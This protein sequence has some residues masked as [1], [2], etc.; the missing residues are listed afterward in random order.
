M[1]AASASGAS[2]T[3]GGRRAWGGRLATLLLAAVAG[4]CAC[5]PLVE[6]YDTPQATL[7]L[8]QAYLC[9]DD[10]E[11]EYACLSLDFQR[12]MGAFDGYYHGRE[13]LLQREPTTAWLF[14]HAN[15]DS[16]VVATNFTP[17]GQKASIVLSAGGEDSVL[18]AFEREAWVTVSWD[19]G[20]H[21][22]ARQAAPLPS[23]IQR[24]QAKRHTWM[25]LPRPEL[26]DEPHIV[27]I[28]Y[29]ARWLISDIAGLAS[30]K[31]AHNGAA[32]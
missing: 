16:H 5:P 25:S 29:S 10:A 6:R 21:E 31:D 30:S 1:A 23:L 15:L 13:D 24:D 12:S 28:R 26:T 9:R 19:D 18:V 4:G 2:V 27:D 8:W 7:D 14:K 32:P 11:G 20:R 17:D 22:V 3:S